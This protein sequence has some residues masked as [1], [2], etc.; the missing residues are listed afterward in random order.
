ME[1]GGNAFYNCELLE[2]ITIPETVTKIGTNAFNY[3]TVLSAIDYEGTKEQ[4]SNI[5][6]SDEW[7]G[8]SLTTIHCSDGDITL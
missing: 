1:I 4:W 3:C 2:K 8:S 6:L 7:R 5:A